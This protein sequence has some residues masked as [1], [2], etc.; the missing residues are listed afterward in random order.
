LGSLAAVCAYFNPCGY[1]TRRR[2]YDIFRRGMEQ[3][4]VTLL[5]VELTFDPDEVS[6]LGSHG[7]VLHIR[8]GDVMWQRERLLQLGI[9][10]LLAD[11]CSA[12]AWL[13]ADIVFDSRT[14][15]D[16]VLRALD[17]FDCVQVFEQLVSSYQEGRMV[18][19]ASA[20]DHRS[21]AHGGGWA[22]T[23]DFWRR[24]KVYQH[25]IL[26]GADSVMANVFFQYR[27]Y[28]DSQF[29]W[30]EKNP[31]MRQF[32]PRLREHIT[33]WASESWGPWRIGYVA[34]QTAHLMAHGARRD[35]RYLDRWQFLEEYE[36]QTDIAI[37]NSGAFRWC[38]DKPQLK[39]AVQDY[40]SARRE[41]R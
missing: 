31:V 11:G 30:P 13:D 2:N 35:R 15:H 6:Q 22:A 39:R 40:F 27:N 25:C 12:L 23:G 17:G 28:G 5:T 20:K 33:A 34:R 29:C 38:C 21:W 9:E 24:V 41:D 32:N 8:G 7:N 19:P 14:W 36:P 26:G 3:S 16:D 10:R 18:R 37:S 4:G 1:Q